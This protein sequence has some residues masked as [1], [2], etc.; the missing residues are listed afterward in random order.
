MRPFRDRPDIKVIGRWYWCP[1]GAIALPFNH[2]FGSQYSD[3]FR[4]EFLEYVVGEQVGWHGPN[5]HRANPRYLGKHWCGTLQDWQEGAIYGQ[6]VPRDWEGIPLCCLTTPLRPGGGL[7][8][9]KAPVSTLTQ[10][11]WWLNPNIFDD[12]PADVD[13]SIWP[14]SA[15]PPND[16]IIS[17]PLPTGMADRM[18]PLY[19]IPPVPGRRNT[20]VPTNNF[21]LRFCSWYMVAGGADTPLT[22]DGPHIVSGIL[23]GNSN[24]VD[25]HTGVGAATNHH[26]AFHSSARRTVYNLWSVQLDGMSLKLFDRGALYA[27]TNVGSS[28]RLNISGFLIGLQLIAPFGGAVTNFSEFILFDHALDFVADFQVLSYLAIK[29]GFSLGPDPVW[30]SAGYFPR[31]YYSR[32]YLP[33]PLR[34]AGV[35]SRFFPIGYYPVHFFPTEYYP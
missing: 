29:Y 16:A 15:G 19:L 10:A 6:T 28:D 12:V 20:I 30:F 26:I 2:A 17:G 13:L 5:F 3:T 11:I 31:A 33:G 9:G 4:E 35:A 14:T 8:G 24:F 7:V 22:L 25:N 1:E 34:A 32:F 23:P 21:T 18:T 27:G